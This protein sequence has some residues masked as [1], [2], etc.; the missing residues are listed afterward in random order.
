MKLVTFAEEAR[1]ARP[2]LVIDD[3]I[4]DLAAEGFSDAPSFLSA[5]WSVQADVARSHAS[6]PLS[7]VRLL[8]PIPSPPRIFGIGLN[9]L[10]HA[11]ESKMK[12][13][14]VPTVFLKL[15]S[16]VVGPGANVVLPRSSSQVDYEA[17]LAVV[18]GRPGYRIA[19]EDAEQH[20]FGYTIV[21]DVS[22]R[23]VQMA[24][25]Q[26][27]L[28]KSFPT[29]TPL[30]PWVVSKDDVGDPSS[31]D[32]SM[33]ISGQVLQES[34]TR[35][36]IFKIP[37]LIEYIS[38]IVP[39]QAGDVISTGTPPGVGMGRS[40]QRWLRDGDEM[41]IRIERIGELRNRVVAEP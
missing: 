19:A 41:V 31:L 40:P 34:N 22:A 6:V 17:E 38:S 7:G 24:T 13:A 29:F 35:L 2:G 16:S 1:S 9:Y 28:A 36:L 32:I 5:P 10:E 18:I 33:T 27:N 15:S 12:V 30:G 4:V 39:L 3:K 20:I 11:S 25:S 8:A 23:D 14:D 21:N 37:Q 26:W